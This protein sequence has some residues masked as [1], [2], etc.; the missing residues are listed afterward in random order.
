LEFTHEASRKE[1]PCVRAA[2]SHT[3]DAN[4]GVGPESIPK[5][6][7]PVLDLLPKRTLCVELLKII[8]RH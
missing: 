4:P 1:N 8:L 7:M 3:S 6:A 5:G 2:D